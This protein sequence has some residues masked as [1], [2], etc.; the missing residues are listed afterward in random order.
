MDFIIPHVFQIFYIQNLLRIPSFQVL[1]Y[2]LLY[3]CNTWNSFDFPRSKDLRPRRC[4]SLLSTIRV[5]FLEFYNLFALQIISLEKKRRREKDAYFV[6][7]ISLYT[8]HRIPRPP[9][10]FPLSSS[11]FRSHVACPRHRIHPLPPLADRRKL[12]RRCP[13]IDT[14]PK[15]RRHRRPTTNN[16]DSSK[17]TSHPP[18]FYHDSNICQTSRRIPW[19]ETTWKA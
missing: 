2:T 12:S 3:L 19:M 4:S 15:T 11:V 14:W 9:T 18:L 13:P 5:L 8:T 16:H 7:I 1:S 17:P 10:L 6:S